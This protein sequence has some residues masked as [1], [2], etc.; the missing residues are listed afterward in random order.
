MEVIG[1]A[2]GSHCRPGHAERLRHAGAAEVINDFAAL[3]SL[4]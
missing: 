2:G 1:F 3:L 4:I